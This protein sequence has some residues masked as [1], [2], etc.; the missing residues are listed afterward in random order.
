MPRQIHLGK[1]DDATIA[2]IEEARRERRQQR[3]DIERIEAAE[4]EPTEQ[5]QAARLV[6]AKRLVECGYH[7][8]KSR[9]LRKRRKVGRHS[10]V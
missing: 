7:D 4:L 9:G 10:S 8:T 1:A 2:A 5:W 3:E 6:V